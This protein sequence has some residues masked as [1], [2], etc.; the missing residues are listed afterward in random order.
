[1]DVTILDTARD[2]AEMN[3]TVKRLHNEHVA[4][5]GCNPFG[6]PDILALNEASRQWHVRAI[7]RRDGHRAP[8]DPSAPREP[9]APRT[10]LYEIIAKPNEDG[11]ITC[12]GPCGETKPHK[13]FP[14]LKG[15]IGRGN[16]C[17]ECR[18]KAIAER[19][20]A[21]RG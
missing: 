13:K 18:D 4:E 5:H 20:A 12:A 11:T 9:K 2:A 15:G 17:R 3:D 1:M 16:V 21:G 14:T 8:R 6:C 10:K 7:A 19:K